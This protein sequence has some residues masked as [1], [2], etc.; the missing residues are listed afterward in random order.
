MSLS[1][2]R[3]FHF[4]DGCSWTSRQRIGGSLDAG[5]LEYRYEEAHAPGEK[6]CDDPCAV[7]REI[8]VGR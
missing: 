1:L 2:E 3:S 4:T 8:R 5:T 7:E 6:G